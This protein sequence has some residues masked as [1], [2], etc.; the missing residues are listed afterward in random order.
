MLSG[1]FP[2]RERERTKPRPTPGR[3]GVQCAALARRAD[4]YYIVHVDSDRPDHFPM[5]NGSPI[6]SQ[7]APLRDNDVIQLAGVKMGFFLSG[8]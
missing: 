1:P 8:S 7:P 2:G 3:P 6:G 4:G 5:L